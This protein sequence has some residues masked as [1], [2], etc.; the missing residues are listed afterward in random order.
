MNTYVTC[1]GDYKKV[2]D[3]LLSF[4]ALKTEQKN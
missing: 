4:K 1:F 3:E 2:Y